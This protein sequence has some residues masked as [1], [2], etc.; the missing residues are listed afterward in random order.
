MI[1]GTITVGKIVRDFLWK[2]REFCNH[3]GGVPLFLAKHATRAVVKT[4]C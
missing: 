4:N 3:A 1:R 2:L